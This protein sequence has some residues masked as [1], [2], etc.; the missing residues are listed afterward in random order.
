MNVSTLERDRVMF[1]EVCLDI[2]VAIDT[3]MALS[4]YLQIEYNLSIESEVLPIQ[5]ADPSSYCND[6]QAVAL[7]SK[8]SWPISYLEDAQ[9]LALF[10]KNPWFFTHTFKDD[11]YLRA[12]SK[13]LD[14]EQQNV[15][16][17]N[18]FNNARAKAPYAMI[19]HSARRFCE[20]I[21]GDV[22]YD[23]MSFSS[24]ASTDL[25]G[26]EAHILGKLRTP[27]V[28]TSRAYEHV[29]RAI[30]TDMP[31]YALACG[32]L[33]RDSTS[34][35]YDDAIVKVS[36]DSSNH[37]TS[38]P[39][40][41]RGDR[42]IC[43]EP[44]G[45]MLL[46]K[47][48]GSRIR[49]RLREFG[50]D[51][52][53]LQDKHGDLAR[54]S[55]LND[56]YSTIDLSSASDTVSRN[57]VREILPVDWFDALDILRCAKTRIEP[58]PSL[59]GHVPVTY[60]YNEKFSSMGNGF[61][62]ELETLLFLCVGLAIREIH[63]KPDMVV[64]VYGDDII[65]DKSLSSH[66]ITA[67]NAFGFSINTEKSF[68][69]GSFKESCGHDYLNGN[70][71]RPIFLKE[72]PDNEILQLVAFANRIRQIS[73]AIGCYQF[74]DSRFRSIWRRIVQRL[75]SNLR[76]FGPQS[77]GDEVLIS[78]FY[79]GKS[80]RKTVGCI[81]RV[82]TYGKKPLRRVLAK[83][84]PSYVLCVALYGVSSHGV[85]PRGADYIVKPRACVISTADYVGR[86]WR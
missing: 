22:G 65:V 18:F 5:Y 14:A 7:L 23:H 56:W 62:F 8:T 52:E 48:Y 58:L 33:K 29:T 25:K 12:E 51:L 72:L 35:R 78:S 75:P 2:L 44:S 70:R 45:N 50:Y 83:G 9:A 79:E 21:L 20:R 40:D 38:V 4:I 53:T 84:E 16:T 82:R 85:V 63:G 57:F 6:V 43:I 34:V 49:N 74:C 59:R 47:G 37:F 1:R 31:H 61:T 77:L 19:L 81:T 68:V 67:L 69:S 60:V 76:L 10:K 80:N 54:V 73:H 28:C 64:S 24:G 41:W 86:E 11:L 15:R 32:I 27:P 17:N 36:P 71:V 55:S 26:K 42:G 3:P 13:F 66:L 39:K 46:Q 30:L